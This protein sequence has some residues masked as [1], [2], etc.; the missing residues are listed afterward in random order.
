MVE[1]IECAAT[2]KRSEGMGVP[3]IYIPIK[4]W[5]LP[6]YLQYKGA[7]CQK[8]LAAFSLAKFTD[9]LGSWYDMAADHLRSHRVPA[10]N[11]FPD[12]PSFKWEDFII[13][14]KFEPVPQEQ[15]FVKFWKPETLAAKGLSQRMGPVAK[16]I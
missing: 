5:P 10:K 12:D 3:V 14:P 8:H 2:G 6:M 13:D 9:Y 11:P 7:L 1:C 4:R 16:T 15:C